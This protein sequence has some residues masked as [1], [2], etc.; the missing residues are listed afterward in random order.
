MH[1]VCGAACQL[2]TFMPAGPKCKTPKHAHPSVDLCDVR[3]ITFVK[4]LSFEWV[5]CSKVCC[6]TTGAGI[7]MADRHSIIMAVHARR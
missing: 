3:N 2:Q 1:H 5:C 4:A 7:A 6:Q